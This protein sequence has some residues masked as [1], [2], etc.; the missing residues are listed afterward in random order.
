MGDWQSKHDY[1]TGA[2]GFWQRVLHPLKYPQ[3]TDS[4]F[5]R[6]H[7]SVPKKECRGASK[8]GN[9]F[10]SFLC[11]IKEACHKKVMVVSLVA[12]TNILFPQQRNYLLVNN[13]S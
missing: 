3:M 9:V 2:N 11:I 1:Q 5:D 8:G 4:T 13:H 6:K 10:T 7:E 12:I